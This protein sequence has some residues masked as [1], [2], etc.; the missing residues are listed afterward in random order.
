MR[1]CAASASAL[2]RFTFD[3]MLRAER[4]V[5]RFSQCVGPSLRLSASIQP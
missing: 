5:K 3:Q 1:P 2:S 4:G